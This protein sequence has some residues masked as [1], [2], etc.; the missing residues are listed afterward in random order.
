MTR[1]LRDLCC[2]SARM[3]SRHTITKNRLEAVR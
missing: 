2:A 1:A 3:R